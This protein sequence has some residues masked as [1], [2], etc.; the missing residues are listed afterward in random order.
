MTV[1][2]VWSGGLLVLSVVAFSTTIC[3][4]SAGAKE[5]AAKISGERVFNQ[6]CASCHQD[7]GNLTVPS[8]AVAG[9]AKL[10]TLALFKDYLNNPLGHMPY[11]K[12]VIDDETTLKALYQY[13]K[14][15][16]KTDIKQVSHHPEHLT[17]F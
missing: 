17:K 5:R 2:N 8:K 3:F 12:N 11:Y 7:G 15:L 13:C 10:S 16:K 4:S 1:N 6:Y 9:S 14:A